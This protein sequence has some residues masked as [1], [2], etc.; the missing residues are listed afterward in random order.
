M[1]TLPRSP[2]D[3]VALIV[4]IER[5]LVAKFVY[6][7]HRKDFWAPTAEGQDDYARSH[8]SPSLFYAQEIL[9][10]QRVSQRKDT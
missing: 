6:P 8:E 10:K 1:V 7:V 9:S 5:T 2:Q 3:G 4:A